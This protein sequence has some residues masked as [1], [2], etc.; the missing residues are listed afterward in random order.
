MPLQGPAGQTGLS[1]ERLLARLADNPHLLPSP[2]GVVMQVLEKASQPGCKPAEL[3]ALIYRDAALYGKIIKTVNSALYGL[4]R[5]VTSIEQAVALLGLNPVRSLVLGLSLPAMQQQA[6]NKRPTKVFW[7]ESI[8]GAIVAHE[9]AIRLRRLCAGDDLVAGLLRD[10]GVLA[11]DQVFPTEYAQVLA[12]PAKE[13]VRNRCQLERQI[14]GVDHAEVSAFLLRRWWLPEDIIEAVRYH[15]APERAGGLP[16]PVAERVHLLAFASSIAQLQLDADQPE[17]L[18]DI[19]AFGRQH[20]G[21]D[22]AALTAFLEPVAKKIEDFAALVDLDIGT[23]EHYPR[24]LAHAA[25]ALAQLTMET[26]VDQLRILEQKRQAEQKTHR[27][28]EE[29]QRDALT[30]A[31]NRGGLEEQLRLQFRRARRRGTVLGAIFI[32]L[33]NFKGINNRFGHLIGD[34]VLKET[35]RSLLAA[36]KRSNLVAR[37]GGDEFC[38]LVENTSPEELK[39][40]ADRLWQTLRNRVLDA[41]GR[42]VSVSASIG[43]VLCLPRTYSQSAT[44]LL[45]VA[46]QAM[47]AAKSSGKN[48]VTFVSLLSD[49]D[50]RYLAAVER[51]RFGTRL[52]GL[53]IE[54]PRSQSLHGNSSGARFE[55]PGRLARRLGWLTTEQLRLVLRE[56]RASGRRFDEIVSERGLLTPDQLAAL[57]ALQLEP[58][59][60][61]A[62][63]LVNQGVLS[64]TTMQEKL[65]NYYRWLTL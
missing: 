65:H 46:D 45:G 41:A 28:R 40:L 13:L 2:P 8:A 53:G 38:V 18:R 23:C 14:V 44:E 60:A 52:R 5:S 34:Y 26:R 16:H 51:R 64:E 11:L 9:L 12:Q 25:E 15:H 36:V 48:Q 56:Q 43:V 33:D 6:G 24:I 30:G 3:A 7:K 1:A 37:Y 57:L 49:A 62:A 31:F 29:L 39:G 4:P 54:I 19:L 27:L 22:D 17:L 63:D 32:D 59:Q 61:L 20:Y 50:R 58:P 10:I 21:L 47:Y 42:R 35:A 55:A